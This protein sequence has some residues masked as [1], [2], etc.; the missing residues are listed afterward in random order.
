MK[1][2]KNNDTSTI[3]FTAP[4]LQIYFFD[5]FR[6]LNQKMIPPLSNECVH[7]LS[8]LMD[9]FALSEDFFEESQEQDGKIEEKIL[10]TKLLKSE[11]LS[12]TVRK[13][14]LQD[15]GDTAL[16][17]VGYFS[18]RLEKRLLDISYYENIGQ[19][20]YLKLNALNVQQ[21]ELPSFFALLAK[22]FQK[23]SLLM[24]LFHQQA[25]ND[26]KDPFSCFLISKSA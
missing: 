5:Q 17:M 4:S 14:V 25:K 3:L 22:E 11:D 20:A 12:P 8:L 9:K 15:I 1:A 26:A 10:G 21:Y 13:K 2:S 7:Y 23:L 19:S 16:F 18:K 6:L 24:N